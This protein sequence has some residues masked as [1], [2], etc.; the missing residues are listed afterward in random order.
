MSPVAAHS[1]TSPPA[2]LN[3]DTGSAKGSPPD[4]HDAHI[5]PN[6]SSSGPRPA[7]RPPVDTAS[8]LV[9][10]LSPSRSVLADQRRTKT[11]PYNIPSYDPSAAVQAGRDLQHAVQ[12][13][14]SE[15]DS[16]FATHYTGGDSPVTNPRDLPA[17]NRKQAPEEEGTIAT[18]E[19]GMAVSLPPQA[20]MGPQSVF[21]KDRPV[22]PLSPFSLVEEDLPSVA[23][24]P[25]SR[26]GLPQY[27]QRRSLYDLNDMNAIMPDSDVVEEDV[28]TPKESGSPAPNTP[29]PTNEQTN[30]AFAGNLEGSA[31][32][33]Q[34]RSWRKGKAKLAGMTIAQSQRRQSRAELGVDKVIDAQLPQPEP[35]AANVRSR[36]ASH[37]LG[38]FKEN[39]GTSRRPHVSHKLHDLLEQK[40]QT[41]N[42]LMTQ[43]QPCIQDDE[44][45]HPEERPLQRLPLDLLEEI[46]NHHHLAPGK[47]RRISYPKAVPGHDHTPLSH[48]ERNRR[49]TEDEDSDREHISSATYF[50]HQGVALGDSP[51]QVPQK[52]ARKMQVEIRGAPAREQQQPQET[53]EDVQIA[54]RSDDA[55]ECLHG[56]LSLSRTPSDQEISSQAKSVSY[57][58]NLLSDSEHESGYSTRGSLSQ[59]S[60]D[61][62]V[63]PTATPKVKSEMAQAKR[64]HRHQP[65]EAVD[66]VELKPYNH[67]VGG[68]TTIY[69]FSRRAVCKQL[70]SK[71]N[72]FYETIEKN[73]PELLGFMPR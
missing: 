26:T 64:I 43:S 10:P 46:R 58:E 29:D 71:E 13:L 6:A 11:A 42:D 53:L 73:H 4:S 2:H 60:D 41:D 54:L 48:Q 35:P 61:E 9:A 47:A 8:T 69:R 5:Q 55:S 21:Y 56:D 57:S 32:R 51:N 67:Q 27:T 34:Y 62:D 1:G 50:P 30:V 52:E 24:R 23:R 28:A 49:E 15:R 18:D 63:T 45:S 66:A 59:A 33:Q 40:E 38:L 44:K 39:E 14:L 16:I 22:S 37:Y 7:H 68:H 12:P 72:M 31:E 17:T 65:P 36:K 3:R 19:P 70:N 20:F 25:V